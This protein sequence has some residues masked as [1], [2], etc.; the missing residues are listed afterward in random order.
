MNIL[1]RKA[2]LITCFS[3]FLLIILLIYQNGFSQKS[4]ELITEFRF[5][6]ILDLFFIFGFNLL[7]MTIWL[8]LSFLL[9]GIIFPIKFIFDMAIM[10]NNF[11]NG[12]FV[13]FISTFP[14]GF[15]EILATSVVIVSF[16]QILKIYINFFRSIISFSKLKEQMFSLIIR[17]FCIITP[18]L[19]V[20]AII[21]VYIS[22]RLYYI[23]MN[24]FAG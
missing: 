10:A 4:V 7:I 24:L 17:F 11:E 16:G 14:H 20:S 12:P 18:L 13:F 5:L 1:L 15:G 19:F 3:Y 23:I 8:S 21:E 22:N 9:I 2:L 6:H